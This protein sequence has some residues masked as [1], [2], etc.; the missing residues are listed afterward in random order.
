MAAKAT[1]GTEEFGLTSRQLVKYVEKVETLISKCMREEGFQYIAADYRTVRKGMSADKNMPGMSEEE[2]INKYGFGVSTFYT[3]KPPQLANGYSPAKSGL[4]ERNI[5]IYKNLSPTDQVAYNR[6]LFGENVNAT[7]AVALETENLS[8]CGGCTLKA[9]K[10]V[11]KPEQLKASYYNPKNTLINKD[12]RMKSA[13]RLYAREMRKAGFDFNHP[14]DVE[15]DVR[16]RV[17]ALTKGG[18]IPI[19]KMS[20]TQ[21]EGLKELQDYE[22]RVAAINLKLQLE[23]FEPVETKIEEEWFSKKSVK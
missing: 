20:P 19:E 14:D 9:I 16:N 23:I 1:M 13:L 6:S 4:G 7:F 22:R 12:P 18:T 3:G 5:Q 21:R 11:F 10:Q 8:F 15:L 17:A 2:F